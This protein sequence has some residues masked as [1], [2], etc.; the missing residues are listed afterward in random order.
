MYKIKLW[1]KKY[2]KEARFIVFN[3]QTH[4]Y[5]EFLVDHVNDVMWTSHD[6]T[7]EPE[8]RNWEDWEDEPVD[9]L[10]NIMM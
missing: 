3:S 10:E 7:K 8:Y 6:L 1:N 5:T 4:K 2:G 9:F